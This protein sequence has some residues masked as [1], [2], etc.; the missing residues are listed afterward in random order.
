M[1]I[2]TVP[3]VLGSPDFG[4]GGFQCERWSNGCGDGLFGGDTDRTS[5][6]VIVALF[7]ISVSFGKIKE[8]NGI[9]G[10]PRQARQGVNLVEPTNLLSVSRA[11]LSD[12]AK[13]VPPCSSFSTAT[14][15]TSVT[16]MK[17]NTVRKCGSR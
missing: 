1:R 3:S 4:G 16:P 10:L 7:F 11:A 5:G 15:V 6:V 13:A 12:S 17:S 8:W 2:T 9:V 14:M